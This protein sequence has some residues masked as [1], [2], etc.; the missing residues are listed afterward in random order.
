M[1]RYLKVGIG[2]IIP[3]ALV[4]QVLKWVIDLS[5]NTLESI[6]GVE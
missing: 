4:F 5:N 3:I 6:I 1:K 2:V